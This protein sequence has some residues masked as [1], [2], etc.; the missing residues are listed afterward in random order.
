MRKVIIAV[1]AGLALAASG[2]TGAM[3]AHGGGGAATAVE[4][5]A[6]SGVAGVAVTS[7]LQSAAA[8]CTL[9]SPAAESGW[10]VAPRRIL[11]LTT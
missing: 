4:A 6:I 3:A 9:I 5:A 2:A 8:G 7:A 1:A 10:R 11:P